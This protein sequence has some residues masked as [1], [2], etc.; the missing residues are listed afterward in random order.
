MNS[1]NHFES[2]SEIIFKHQISL[3]DLTGKLKF[4]ISFVVFLLAVI[5]SFAFYSSTLFK[6]FYLF[7]FFK[8]WLFLFVVVVFDLIL[9]LL[10]TKAKII[11]T[12]S[13]IFYKPP[14]SFKI[15]SLLFD[16]IDGV[17]KNRFFLTVLGKNP[18]KRFTVFLYGKSAED[19][20]SV[21][22]KSIVG[23]KDFTPKKTLDFTSIY[24]KYFLII[25]LFLCLLGF[26][27]LPFYC[28]IKEKIGDY[29]FSEWQKSN[30]TIEIYRKCAEDNYKTA[31]LNKKKKLYKYIKCI[32]VYNSN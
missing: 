19:F 17:L 5:A 15:Y 24:D 27:F 18:Q 28:F 3:K 29:Y 30:Y 2:S 23:L 16:E 9:T 10:F 6:N 32:E 14:V 20:L 7:F 25:S 12:K 1:S 4:S 8:I 13:A 26:Y 31:M 11:L 21:L 22:Q